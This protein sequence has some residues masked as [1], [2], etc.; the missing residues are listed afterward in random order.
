MTFEIE[1]KLKVVSLDAVAIQ[2]STSG[3]IFQ[4]QQRQIDTYF[5]DW[6]SSMVSSDCALRLREQKDNHDHKIIL[7]YKGPKQNG[8]MKT[9]REIELEITDFDAM[10]NILIALGYKESVTVE[11]IRDLWLLDGCMVCLDKLTML[12][13]FVEIEGP[14]E[15]TIENVARKLNLSELEHM[16]QSYAN[17]IQNGH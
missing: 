6:E 13:T 14:C 3:A 10:K 15:K 1:T 5:D 9:R 2:L 8:Q 16:H 11:K 4:S 17:M 7:T 12:G